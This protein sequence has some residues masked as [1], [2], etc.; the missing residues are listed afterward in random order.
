MLLVFHVILL[1][2]LNF[3]IKL[4]FIRHFSFAFDLLDCCCQEIHEEEDGPYCVF[5]KKHD[6]TDFVALFY[7]FHLFCCLYIIYFSMP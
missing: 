3:S 7:F 4:E 5:M 2:M 6:A 1:S